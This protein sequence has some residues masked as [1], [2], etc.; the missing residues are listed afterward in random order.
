MSPSSSTASPSASN[1]NTDNNAVNTE[2]QF[3][4]FCVASASM[5]SGLSAA[6]TQRA[7]SGK[8]SRHTML[9]SAEMAVY[10]IVFLLGNLMVNGEIQAGSTLWAHWDLST[11]FPVVTNVSNVI[12]FYCVYL[13]P[14]LYLQ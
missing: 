5:L 14:S 11:M 13:F 1:D 6:L 9:Y 7:L 12:F 3:G 8:Q 2:Y 10:G 4:L